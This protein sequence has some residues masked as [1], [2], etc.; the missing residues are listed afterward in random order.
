MSEE[1]PAEVESKG[2]GRGKHFQDYVATYGTTANGANCMV[3]FDD[4]E[5]G[6]GA[7]AGHYE[8]RRGLPPGSQAS[9]KRGIWG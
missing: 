1:M 5:V 6:R 9:W 2:G 7:G 8:L 4:S 3:V